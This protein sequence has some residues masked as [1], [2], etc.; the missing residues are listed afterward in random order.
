LKDF[1]SLPSLATKC[2]DISPREVVSQLKLQPDFME[3]QHDIEDIQN[4]MKALMDRK[5][6]LTR[7]VESAESNIKRV[8]NWNDLGISY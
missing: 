8:Q 1:L 3:I 5:A 7:D 4:D 6:I 2:D